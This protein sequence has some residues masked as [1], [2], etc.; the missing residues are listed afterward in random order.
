VRAALIAA[1]V[2][3]LAAAP[4]GASLRTYA[5][6]RGDAYHGVSDTG[7]GADF[8]AFQRQVG[9]HPAML[10]E[11]F[12]WDVPLK[13]SGAME[14]WARTDTRGV[15]HLSTVTGEGEERI[16]PRQLAD[17]RGDH[18][19]LRLNETIG[20]NDLTVY[21]RLFAEMNGHWN[22][23]C[24]YNADGTWRGPSHSAYHYKQAWRRIVTIVRGGP[25]SR[26]NR[27]LRRLGMPRIHRAESNGDPVYERQDV[28]EVLPRA[29]ASFMWVPQTTGSPYVAGNQPEDYWPGGR[30]V[31]WVGADIYAAFESAGFRE[32]TPF[33]RRWDRWPFVIGE[34]S[35]W[36]SDYDGSFVRHLF[37]WQRN[38]PRTKMLLYYRS[39]D[40]ENP[41]NVDRY[42]GAQ[43]ALRVTLNR[44]ARYLPFAPGTRN[45]PLPEP[46]TGGT[47]P[48]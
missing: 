19:A 45:Q 13:S 40:T 27:K 30:Y 11:F 39:N 36:D 10:Q 48:P 46:P 22:A 33:Y 32:L 16:T 34:Y 26:I 8:R 21:I 4:A 29:R 7:S 15:V 37:R 6:K 3:L 1:L 35:P 9:A 44:T 25:R 42:P 41:H 20:N 47:G 24:A 12:H 14:R 17:G 31:D 43:R 18:Y 23:Y 38:H 2:A 5:P 28:P